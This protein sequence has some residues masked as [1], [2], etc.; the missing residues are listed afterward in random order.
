MVAQRNSGQ[1]GTLLP[2]MLAN[3]IDLFILSTACT[4]N[5]LGTSM[6]SYMLCLLTEIFNNI[7]KSLWERLTQKHFKCRSFFHWLLEMKLLSVLLTCYQAFNKLLIWLS[8]GITNGQGLIAACLFMYFPETRVVHFI[9]PSSCLGTQQWSPSPFP[10]HWSAKSWV[11]S[12][13]MLCR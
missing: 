12:L 4:S 8:W 2:K 13:E 5:I 3:T 11:I 6:L 10:Q 9:C 1:V 7:E